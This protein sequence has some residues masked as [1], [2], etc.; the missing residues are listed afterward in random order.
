MS[1]R[2]P[3]GS[4][5][6]HSTNSVLELILSPITQA[7]AYCKMCAVAHACVM[8]QSISS[9]FGECSRD[10]HRGGRAVTTIFCHIRKGLMYL[11]L[12]LPLQLRK[13]LL[14]QIHGVDALGLMYLNRFPT[15]GGLILYLVFWTKLY[16]NRFP[17]QGGLI[18][19]PKIMELTSSFW[20]KQSGRP[21]VPIKGL[22]TSSIGVN[23]MDQSFRSLD[24]SVFGVWIAV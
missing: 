13:N 22:P 19:D 21:I 6:L 10:S 20:T 16:L 1:Y 9:L 4:L 18:L 8:G 12:E 23:R 24:Q 5:S 2:N 7:C 17:T 3:P 15:Q 14:E 11:D